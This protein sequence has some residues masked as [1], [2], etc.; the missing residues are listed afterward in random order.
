[1]FPRLEE[2]QMEKRKTRKVNFGKRPAALFLAALLLSMKLIPCLAAFPWQVLAAQPGDTVTAYGPGFHHYCI[3]GTGANRALIDGDEYVYILPS[4]TLSREETSIAFWGML[5]LQAGFGNVP[6]INAVIRNINAGASAAG[7]QPISKFVTEADLKLLIHSAAVRA[8]YPWLQS[9]LANEERYLQLACLLGSGSGNESGSG[10]SG[11]SGVPSVLQGHTDPGNPSMMTVVSGEAGGSDGVK[12]LRLSFDESGADAEFIRSVPLLFSATGADGSFSPVLP[13]GWVCQKTDTEILLTS[14]SNAESALYLMFDVRGTRYGT[15]GSFS[16]VE[17]V[18]EQSLQIWR[19]SRCAGTHK[20][21]YNGAAPLAAHQRLAFIELQA[22]EVCYYAAA[23]RAPA[24]SETGSMEFEVYRHEEDWVSTY[25]VRLRKYDHETGKTLEN[26]VFSLYE[27][28]DDKAEIRTDRDGAVTLYAGGAPYKSYHKDSPVTWEDFRFV[29]ALMTD[30]NGEAAK[31]V[32]HGYHY[33]KT[34]CD[35][36]PAPEFV[37]VP[38]EEED[39]E[40]GETENQDEIEAAQEENRRLARLWLDTEAACSAWA[41]GAFS[42]VH[43]HWIMP[44]VDE[45]EIQNAAESGGEPGE[46]PSAGE[47]ASAGGARAWSDSGCEADAGETYEKFISLKY[48]YAIA[49]DTAREGYTLHGNHAD[50]LPIEVITTDASENGANAVFAGIYGWNIRVNDAVG[51]EPA[52][53]VMEAR[54][55]AE[56]GTL[57]QEVP[58]VKKKRIPLLQRLRQIFTFRHADEIPLTD[59]RETDGDLASGSDAGK[60]SEAKRAHLDTEQTG[61][62]SGEADMGKASGSNAAKPRMT[63]LRTA[64]PSDADTI[65]VTL[66]LRFPDKTSVS[67]TYTSIRGNRKTD[68]VS[69]EYF[70]DAYNSALHASSSGDEVPT[71]PSGNYSHCGN[72]DGEDNWWR[73]YDHRTEGELHINKRDMDLKEGESADYDSYGD[74][75][76]DA[77]LEG[78][79]YGLF[80]A[81]DLVHPDGKSGIVYH[82]NDLTAVAATDKNGDA[83]FLV[84]TEEPGMTYRY[85]LGQIMQRDE[86]ECASERRR[87]P[88]NLYD[89]AHSEDDYAED[90]RYTR[91]YADNKGINGNCW[92]GRPLLMGNYYVKELSRSEGYELSVGNRKH[93]LTNAG[94]DFSVSAEES[95]RD[96]YA[97]ITEAFYA[98]QQVRSGATGAYGD[99]TFRELFFTVESQNS[100]GFDLVFSGLPAGTRLYRLDTAEGTEPVQVGTG[101]MVEVPE[102]DLFGNPVYAV[103]E[104]EGQYPQ[105]DVDGNLLTRERP[106][107]RKVQNVEMITRKGLDETRCE[108]LLS[109]AENGMDE[110]A[111]LEKLTAPFG[112]D[113]QNFVKHKLER[114]LRAHGKG[115]PRRM[116]DGGSRYTTLEDPVYDTGFQSETQVSYGAPVVTLQIPQMQENR[117]LLTTGDLL[118]VLLN[119]YQTNSQ[120]SYGGIDQIREE[121]D[122]WIVSIYAGRTGNPECFFAPETDTQPAAFYRRTAYVPDDPA[123]PPRYLYAVYTAKEQEDSFGVYTEFAEAAGPADAGSRRVSAVLTPDAAA[124]PDGTLVTRYIT[125]NMYYQPGEIPLDAEGNRIPKVRY[126]EETITGE[127][128]KQYTHWTEIAW[129][130]DNAAHVESSY[131]DFYGSAQNDSNGAVWKWKLVLPGAEQVAL[132]QEDVDVLAGKSAQWAPGDQM[133]AAAYWLMVKHAKVQAYLDYSAGQVGDENSYVRSAALVYPGQAFVWQDG[134]GVPGNGTGKNPIG[135]EERIIRQKI[136]VGKRI[137]STSYRNTDSYADIHEDLWTKQYDKSESVENFR[138]KAY[139]KS[140]LQDLYRNEAGTVIWQDRHGNERTYEEQRQANEQFPEKVNRIYTKVLHRTKPLFKNSRDAATA[141]TALYAYEDG[142]ISEKAQSGYSAILETVEALVEDGADTRTVLRLNYEKFFDAM[143]TANHDKWD[144]ASPEYTSFRPLGN[145]VNR[146]DETLWNTLVSDRVRQFAIDWYLDDEVAKLTDAGGAAA[147]GS[148]SFTDEILDAGLYQAIRKAQNYLKPFFAYDL[149]ELYAVNWDGEEDGGA[150]GDQATL[151]ANREPEG[152]LAQTGYYGISA[153]LP[154]GTYVIAEQQPKYADL[155]DFKNRHYE[156]DRTQEISL[157]AV[158]AD[159]EEGAQASPGK[160]DPYYHYK[161]AYTAQELEQRYQIRF[162][163]ESHVIRAHSRR[164][165]FEVYKYGLDLDHV[166]NGVPE[167]PGQGDYFAVTQSE[168]RPFQNSYND[169]DGR[170]AGAVSYYLSEGQSG[171]DAVSEVY[172]YSSLS[173]HGGLADAVAYPGGEAIEDNVPGIMYRDQVTVMQGAQTAYDNRYAPMLVP[174]AVTEEESSVESSCRPYGCAWFCN[175]LFTSRIRIE[176]L[177]SATHENILHDGAV[178]HIY[179]ASRDDS[180]DGD[181]RVLFYKKDTQIQGTKDFL[182]EM[183]A[184]DIRPVLRGPVAEMWNRVIT[185]AARRIGKP[186]AEYEAGNT[187]E[188]LTEDRVGH[189]GGTAVLSDLYT[190]IVAA[191]TPVCE[192][193]EQ[194]ILGDRFGLQTGAMKAF[195]TVRDGQLAETSSE[196]QTVGY[197]NTPQPLSAGT[198]VLCEVRPPA[199][200]VR[201]KPVALELYSDQI[202]YYQNGNRDK[203]INAAVYEDPADEQTANRNKP[204]DQIHTARVYIENEPIRLQVE[205]RTVP[206]EQGNSGFVSGAK[207]T[208]FD[209]VAL[210]PSGDSQDFAYEGL[211]VERSDAGHV[212]RMYVKEGYGGEKTEFLPERDADGRMYTTVWPSGTDR[213]GEILEAEGYVWNAVTVSRPDTDILY[214]DLSDLEIRI[215]PET[216]GKDGRYRAFAWKG[217]SR[218]L[219]FS[220]GDLTEITYGAKDHVLSV[221]AGTHVYHLGK[222]GERDALVDPYTGMAYVVSGF[223]G[224]NGSW[225]QIRGKDGT[226]AEKR[227]VFVWPVNIRRDEYGN[228]ISRD[229]ITTSRAALAG[230]GEQSYL[231]GSWKSETWEESHRESTIRQNQEG[232]NL[233]EEIL[234]GDNDGSFEKKMNPVYDR[235]GLAV[236]YPKSGETY[237]KETALYDRNNDPVRVQEADGLEAYNHAAYAVKEHDA[238]HDSWGK[239]EHRKGEAYV[240]ENTWITSESHPNDPFTQTLTEGGGDILERVPAGCYIMEEV[241]APEGFARAFPMAVQVQE[242]D[243]IQTVTMTDHTIKTEFSKTDGVQNGENSAFACG[244]VKGAALGLW[245]EADQPEQTEPVRTWITGEEPYVLEQI[246]AGHYLWKELEVPSG[247]VSREPMSITVQDRPEVQ[248]YVMPEEH[249]RVEVEKYCLE[250]G[251]DQADGEIPVGGAGF[252]L[253]AA[254]LDA[255][256]NVCYADGKPQPD[257]AQP[258]ASWVTDDGTTYQGFPDAFEEMYLEHGVQPGSSVKWDAG[259]VLH[260]ADYE[261]AYQKSTIRAGQARQWIFVYRTETGQ[262]IRVGVTEEPDSMADH[263]YRFEYQFNWQKLPAINE[264]ACTYLTVQNRQRFD[265]LPIHQS[266]VLVE[267]EVPPGFSQAEN[268]LIR[269]EDTGAVQEY[270]V[271]NAEGTLLIS[272]VYADGTKELSGVRLALY[273]ADETGGFTRSSKYLFDA[274]VTGS[275]GRYSELDALNRRIPDGYAEGDL[276]PHRVRK[277]PDGVYWLA[278]QECPGYYTTLEPVQIVYEWQPEIRIVRVSN[279]LVTGM[280]ELRKTDSSGHPLDG[281]VFELAAYEEKALKKPWEQKKEDAVFHMQFTAPVQKTGLPVG[282]VQ[283][284]GS[285]QPFWYELREI[286]APDGYELNPEVFRWQFAPDTGAGPYLW[287]GSAHYELTVTDRKEPE[288]EKPEPEEPEPETPEPETPEPEYPEPEQPKPEKPDRPEHDHPSPTP[289]QRIGRILAWYQ[290]ASPDDAGWFFLGPAGRLKIRLPQMGD[291][292]MTGVLCGVFAL[293]AAGIIALCRKKRRDKNKTE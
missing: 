100:G 272:K 203:R 281:A 190:G 264:Y 117:E 130:Q 188:N 215:T 65:S 271:E 229:K 143:E 138:F 189:A 31:T 241:Q 276:R 49:E 252:T 60:V 259:T 88:E 81:E 20:Q 128:R 194:V 171:R 92:I 287:N 209:A 248:S 137:E 21:M 10:S 132:S 98:E 293:S 165:D 167:H 172:R 286:Q 122:F 145:A 230:D 261:A 24:A 257:A 211:V 17:E 115:T 161:A 136:R 109:Q 96:G 240:M 162:L 263:A 99:P 89:R 268:V 239:L 213:Y 22:P 46:T 192:E 133:G 50:D 270:H 226:G 290:P 292:R 141:N 44:E 32:E 282:T 51:A 74:S 68:S 79:V 108:V 238:L 212:T 159:G 206:D 198:Y 217:A 106:V 125:E 195:V 113:E 170:T 70:T 178:F 220:G 127:T 177:D 34:F 168:Y 255:D 150:D 55:Q 7:L 38:E 182:T 23:G 29:S 129:T 73:I 197:L 193:N 53:K 173:E 4:E 107:S 267:T 247:F 214:Y 235:H 45:S 207:M 243:T 95:S 146:R 104:Y 12:Q 156:T 164:G 72:G 274:W 250:N 236:Y 77:V 253:Y 134:A 56:G 196:L 210:N 58:D 288:P 5:T 6:Q 57:R 169:Q 76:G 48:S 8:K 47:T 26:A 111:V 262:Q 54:K 42:G 112:L 110:V 90:G 80:A 218:F 275:D 101:V 37:P 83:S 18:Y 67:E 154:Y 277:L 153:A 245:K 231:T 19:C 269:V 233:N 120:H 200:Y 185:A 205:K 227:Q 121:E 237:D 11:L 202:T 147:E 254:L 62:A 280:L 184:Q 148:V 258:V 140:N 208:L 179:A 291:G 75:Q 91:D 25:N 87:V 43:F 63:A 118:A 116:S 249:T 64:T 114:I 279:R 39:E 232:N 119:Y 142:M 175:R 204:Q 9:V 219:E 228:I 85:D 40:S 3:D 260:R 52:A 149:D 221:D 35:G 180:P 234:L 201:T 144:D 84:Y 176:K 102:T 139:L 61:A 278:E 59:D 174:Y 16:S 191:G 126:E 152:T 93:P 28:F 284:D 283:A 187:E 216:D 123:E 71:G 224:T 15:G 183:G 244:Y 27:R 86:T 36:H 105:Y 289:M 78:A 273:R 223:D 131:T 199:G 285:V 151:C 181:G 256:G 94:Q 135:V 186:A 251:K 225:D 160:L 158:Y 157:P 246:P 155:E 265:Y 41:S 69:S 14:T 1:M 242:T 222:N 266:F 2:R 30:E 33:D 66:N 163:E 103:T 124:E 97:V 82:K 166:Q 13:E